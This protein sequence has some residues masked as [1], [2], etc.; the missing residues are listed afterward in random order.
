MSTKETP[1]DVGGPTYLALIEALAEKC[2]KAYLAQ[3]ILPSNA[4]LC[5][6]RDEIAEFTRARTKGRQLQFLIRNGIR[7]Y[8]DAGGWPVVTRA[9]VEGER[10]A[11][12][13]APAWE[14]NKVKPMRTAERLR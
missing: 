5:L 3:H 2:V 13:P 14:S 8:V 4:N 6:S 10:D 9:A 7:H 12:P 11:S 1:I